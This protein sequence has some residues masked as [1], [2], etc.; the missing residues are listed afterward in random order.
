TLGTRW[1]EVGHQV[2]WGSR[3]PDAEKSQELARGT[4]GK[5]VSL[6]EAAESA[7]T[8]VLAI[9]WPVARATIESIGPLSGKTI[10][11]CTNP[12]NADFSGLDLG[13]STSAAEEIASWAPDAHVVK[14]FNTVSS[15]TMADP[16]YTDQ[17][18][19]MF[20]CGNDVQAKATVQQLAEDIGLEAVDAGPLSNA[21]LL[22][23]LAMLYIHLAV[24]EGWGSNCAFKI[25]KR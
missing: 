3:H 8:I 20:F 9:P 18:A 13:F 11:D 19:S 12:L 23:P 10:V 7:D 14:A 22:E 4:G 2:V 16:T 25:L 17:P 5:A 21:R 15:V 24:R 1:I 6:R